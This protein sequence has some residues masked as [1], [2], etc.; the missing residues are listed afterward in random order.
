MSNQ[1]AVLCL[2]ADWSPIRIVSWEHA[3]ELIL[4][5]KVSVVEADP[6]RFV[7][8]ERLAMQ[9]PLVIALRKY[10]SI[11]GRV[12]FSGK[13]VIVRD[14]GR[15]NYCGFAPRTPDGRIDR[16]TLTHD[17]V[18]PR[19]QAK[20]GKVFLPWSRKWVN[21]TSWEN[22]TTA[23]RPCNMRK[24]DRTPDQAKMK[25]LVYPRIPTQ[26]DVLRMSLSK[27]RK[28]PEIWNQY[29]PNILGVGAEVEQD[30]V[31]EKAR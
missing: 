27:V 14:L 16:E 6:A 5:G 24:A 15:C 20:D 31:Q 22:A 1:N 19:A 2:N 9:W 3:I 29:L 26:A 25:L 4:E 18:V 10:R 30:S 13:H 28:V 8:S 11:R 12:K 23:C 21:V 7:R 17:H